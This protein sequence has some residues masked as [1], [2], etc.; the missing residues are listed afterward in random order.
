MQVKYTVFLNPGG[1]SRLPKDVSELRSVE[2]E[3]SGNDSI[4]ELA[5]AAEAQS[6]ISVPNGRLLFPSVP[7][8]QG[9]RSLAG[10]PMP[11][12]SRTAH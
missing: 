7:D 5:K 3:A 1:T 6:G 9:A 2:L 11:S 4:W 10:A 8:A 12:S